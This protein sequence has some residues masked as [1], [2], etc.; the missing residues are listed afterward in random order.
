MI[1]PGPPLVLVAV[2][3]AVVGAACD[4]VDDARDRPVASPPSVAASPAVPTPE[5]PRPAAS[6]SPLRSPSLPPSPAPRLDAPDAARAVRL[7]GLLADDVGPRPSGG[8]GDRVARLTVAS[9]LREAG[10]DVEEVEVTLPQGGSSA[11]VVATWDGRGATGPHVV[12][13]A[14]LDTVDGSPGGND[15]A[16]GVGAVVALAAELADEAGA[17]AVPVVLVAFAAEEYQP[18]T[19]RVHHVGSEQY[20]ERRGD[21][22]VAMLSL[23]MLGHGPTTCICWFGGGP[24][25]LADRLGALAGDGFQVERRGDLSD[26]GPFARRV[27][28]AAFL[29]TYLEPRWHSPE[30]TAAHLQVDAVS[31]SVELTAAFVRDLHAADSDGLEAAR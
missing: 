11:N 22:V 3:V 6:P 21:D 9:W 7:A 10:W 29:W 2:L 8:R 30:D 26:H 12:I 20:A 16:S 15:N 31:R 28:P 4:A 25:T 24:R 23:D 5:S 18:S 19:P 14:H 17:L 13:G 1:R 27:V